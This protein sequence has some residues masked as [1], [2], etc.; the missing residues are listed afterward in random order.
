MVWSFREPFGAELAESAEGRDCFTLDHPLSGV[1][2][3]SDDQ[4]FIEKLIQ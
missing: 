3:K 1:S 2:A 4:L